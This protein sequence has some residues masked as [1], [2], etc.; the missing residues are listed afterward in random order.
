MTRLT[1]ASCQ[2]PYAL[3]TLSE[4]LDTLWNSEVF[5]PYRD[6]FPQEHRTSPSAFKKHV[7]DLVAADVKAPYLKSLQGYL[8]EDGYRS[9]KIRAPLFD[10]VGPAMTSW[11]A[12]G[13]ALMIYSSGS[14]PAQKLLFSHT[15]AEPSDLSPLISDWFDTVNAGP[16]T[17][18][19]SYVKIASK[20]PDIPP[21]RW[22][23][24]S[25]NLAEVHAA[26]KSGMLSLPVT[27]P[28]NAPIDDVDAISRSVSDFNELKL[29]VASDSWKEK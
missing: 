16:K 12:A 4:D 10:D 9:G 17:E 13:L 21:S 26:T 2:F 1:R 14:V 19:A 5:A 8:W 11:H 20:Y 24:L 6:A 29:Q 23:F 3:Q 15:T 25:D 7:D 27:R 18:S 28:G 22:L